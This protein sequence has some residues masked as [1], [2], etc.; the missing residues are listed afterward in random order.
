MKLGT[1]LANGQSFKTQNSYSKRGTGGYRRSDRLRERDRHTAKRLPPL[2]YGE[3]AGGLKPERFSC[4]QPCEISHRPTRGCCKLI[5]RFFDL[6]TAAEGPGARAS[7]SW[8]R[9]T[10]GGEA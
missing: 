9:E 1:P 3:R 10:T 7:P 5:E 4:V 8:H 2:K 6:V